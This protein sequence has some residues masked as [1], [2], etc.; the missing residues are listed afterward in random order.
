[1]FAATGNTGLY[2][3]L[4]VDPSGGLRAA[5]F[6]QAAQALRYGVYD[7]I[8]WQLETVLGNVDID[9]LS[10]K[11]DAAGYAH[12]AFADYHGYQQSDLR[13]VYWDG[14]AWQER[15]PLSAAGSDPSLALASS[16][17]SHVAY[18]EIVNY[19]AQ[20]TLAAWNGSSWETRTVAES[21]WQPRLLLDPNDAIYV[22]F[23][24]GTYP[25]MRLNLAVETGPT[26]WDIRRIASDPSLSY[27]D[28]ALDS[29]GWLHAVYQVDDPLREWI[30]VYAVQTA[31]G[32]QREP[33][34]SEFGEG[35]ARRIDLALD[36]S[37]RPHISSQYD[38]NLYYSTRSAMGWETTFWL[39]NNE[40]YELDLDT[41]AYSGVV[42]DSEG[43]PAIAY[44]GEQDLKLARPAEP[45]WYYL[46]L[47]L[48]Q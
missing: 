45:R 48:S 13:Y 19:Q 18:T 11:L 38:H 25:D 36:A 42:L 7:G 17:A 41:G 14:L 9:G 27:H 5:Y 47:A 40:V 22:S 16:G 12:I 4:Q 35:E 6:D 28:L 23:L 31:S 29:A 8:G 30:P 2:V 39:D 3:D 21:G 37:D 15:P 44:Y 24:S 34:Y 10:L 43:K 26:T 32:W 20:V 33:V 46:P 1:V